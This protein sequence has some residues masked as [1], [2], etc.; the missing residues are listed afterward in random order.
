MTPQFV[1]TQLDVI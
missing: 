1:F